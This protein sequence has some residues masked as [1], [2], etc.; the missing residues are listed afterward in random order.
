MNG[1]EFD[2]RLLEPLVNRLANE[3]A[4]VHGWWAALTVALC[5]NLSFAASNA[6]ERR[7]SISTAS[8]SVGLRLT[9]PVT[10]ALPP[11]TS[12]PF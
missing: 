5:L 7:W 1:F 4:T 6:I 3:L 10:R 11:I 9:R 12:R 2:F 8:S